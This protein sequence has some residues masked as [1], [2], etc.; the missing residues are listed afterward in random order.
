M[1]Y[2]SLLTESYKH[3]A[4]TEQGKTKSSKQAISF[5]KTTYFLYSPYFM[6]AARSGPPARMRARKAEAL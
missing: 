2:I 3:L 5:F 4:P 1:F 6:R